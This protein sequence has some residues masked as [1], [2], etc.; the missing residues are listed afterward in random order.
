VA[1]H[2]SERFNGNGYYNGGSSTQNASCALAS[3]PSYNA[4]NITSGAEIALWV[5]QQYTVT[6]RV[7]APSA[8]TDAFH[9]ASSTGTNLS[10]SVNIPATGGW[11]DWTSVTATVTLPAGQQTLTVDQDTGG[12]NI[13]TLAFS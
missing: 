7:A 5:W 9:I 12:W 10:G 4:E 2:V 6:F 8:V 1:L 3:S 11:Q 13:H